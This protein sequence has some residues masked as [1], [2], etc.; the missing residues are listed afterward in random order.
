MSKG[1]HAVITAAGGPADVKVVPFD[2]P[3][4]VPAKHVLVRVLAS[5]ATY[6]DLLVCAGKCVA[7]APAHQR[8]CS[9]LQP[10][11]QL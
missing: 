7:P 3:Q 11:R 10:Q 1:T 4:A 8:S 2:V 5:T 6:T 9:R